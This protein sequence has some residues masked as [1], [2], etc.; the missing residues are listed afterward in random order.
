MADILKWDRRF[1]ELADH[2]AGWSKDP[3]TKVGAV[4]VNDDN[5][6]VGL[7]Y[8]GF[9]RGVLDLEN[10]LLDREVKYQMVVHAE[11]NAILMAGERAKGGT[12]YTVPTLVGNPALCTECCK[13]V[14]QSG[15][16]RTVCRVNKGPLP[17]RWAVMAAR[18]NTMCYEAGIRMDTI[19]Y[20]IG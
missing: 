3:S 15:I 2:V 20:N 5:I 13:A 14:I 11:L 8:N 9:P 1:L 6:V 12:I 18:V 7:G 4:I 16:K 19:D 17:D 10:R